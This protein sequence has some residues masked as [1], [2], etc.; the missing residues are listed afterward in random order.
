MRSFLSHVT[1]FWWL[2]V[3]EAI[4]M[5]Q[6]LIYCVSLTLIILP[7]VIRCSLTPVFS[8]VPGQSV[9]ALFYIVWCDKRMYSNTR[10]RRAHP[11]FYACYLIQYIQYYIVIQTTLSCS[12]NTF[13]SYISLHQ[14]LFTPETH[15]Y[16]YRNKGFIFWRFNGHSE[17]LLQIYCVH[18]YTEVW[19][20][21]SAIIIFLQDKALPI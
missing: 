14:K 2:T 21:N 12:T 11:F 6:S 20:L 7:A 9:A 1:V 10:K 17:D 5:A 15:H 4:S 8:D 18:L 16:Q 19:S 13:K 3:S